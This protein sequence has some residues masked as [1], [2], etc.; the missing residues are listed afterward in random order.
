MFETSGNKSF[1][2]RAIKQLKLFIPDLIHNDPYSDL[3][4]SDTQHYRTDEHVEEH[5]RRQASIEHASIS[6]TMRGII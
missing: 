2:I 3:I 5:D 4:G 1:D 6:E